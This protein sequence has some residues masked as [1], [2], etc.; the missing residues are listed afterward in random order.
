[1][2]GKPSMRKEDNGL[3]QISCKGEV[4]VAVLSSL[5]PSFLL[6]LLVQQQEEI[7]DKLQKA[8]GT[9]PLS[10]VARYAHVSM[11]CMAVSNRTSSCVM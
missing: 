3:P 1:M 8:G 10:G 5:L 2:P 4:H 7:V 9:L 6:V 11:F